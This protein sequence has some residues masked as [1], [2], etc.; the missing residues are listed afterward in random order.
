METGESSSFDWK[1]WFLWIMATTWGWLLGGWL[2][3]GVAMLAS[4][5]AIAILQWLVLQHR[6]RNAWLWILAS[7]AGWMAGWGLDLFAV[8]TELGMFSG[9][10]LGAA[11]GMAQWMILRRE[12]YWAGWWIV[13]SALAWTTGLALIPGTLTSGVMPGAI[14]GIALELLLRNPKVA[15]AGQQV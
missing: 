8:P 12:V 6:I 9:V 2:I 15:T 11:T 4:G 10:V 7:T 13:I 14:T 1:L 5:I 3:A